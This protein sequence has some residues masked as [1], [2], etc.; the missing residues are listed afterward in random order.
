MSAIGDL[1]GAGGVSSLLQTAIDKIWPDP[2]K[3][4]EAKVALLQAEQAGTFKEMDQEFQL[5]LE[6]IKTNAVEAASPSI[7][8][9]GWRPFV[10]WICGFGLGY[11]A[12]IEP[13]GRFV[14][15]TVFHYAGTFPALDTTITM[16]A[17]FGILGLGAMRSYDKVKGVPS[18]H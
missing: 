1:F 13:L 5:S 9:A 12:I 10:G 16:Q 6:Q 18:G 17:L 3:A 15:V 14:A 8:V 4:A 11:A 2:A 7:F